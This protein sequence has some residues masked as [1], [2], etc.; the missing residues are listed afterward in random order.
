M[1]E[2]CVPLTDVHD[3]LMKICHDLILLRVMVVWTEQL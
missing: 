2:C 1:A 3:A